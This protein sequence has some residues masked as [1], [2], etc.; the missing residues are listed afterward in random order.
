MSLWSRHCSMSDIWGGP[1]LLMGLIRDLQM[2]ACP[3][4]TGAHIFVGR[5]DSSKLQNNRSIP[6]E[7]SMW[8][9]PC[10]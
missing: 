6:A 2:K 5:T 4:P 10:P 7:V 1:I 8:C 9:C 3:N